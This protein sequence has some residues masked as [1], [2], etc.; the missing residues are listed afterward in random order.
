MEFVPPIFWALLVVLV[1]TF[2][3]AVFVWIT[4]KRGLAGNIMEAGA[5]LFLVIFTVFFVIY[6][7]V[8]RGKAVLSWGDPDT[9]RIL[10]ISLGVSV[11][12]GIGKRF[13]DPGPGIEK[14]E[15]DFQ[16]PELVY[17]FALLRSSA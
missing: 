3:F 10:L 12:W 13:A 1:V 5:W 8:T 17:T 14:Q 9:I 7:M 2:C 4:G 6:G 11:V 16:S 15:V